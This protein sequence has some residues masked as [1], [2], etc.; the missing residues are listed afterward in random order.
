VVSLASEGRQVGRHGGEIVSL[1]SR[2]RDI[3]YMTVNAYT[4]LVGYDRALKIGPDLLERFENEGDRVFTFT[5]REGHRWSDGHPFT[6]E[7]FRFWWEDIARNKELSPA[8]L[9]DFMLVEGEGPRFELIDARTIRYTWTKPNPRFLPTLAQPRDPFIYRPAHYLKQFHAKYGDKAKLAE[10][11]KAQK[12]K[13]WAGLFNRLD[14]MFEASNP[15]LP[16]LHG[17][18]VTNSSPATR[19]VFERNPFYHRVDEA[20]QQLPYL[21]R[22]LMDVAAGGL[23]AAKANSGDAD[24]LARGLTMGDIP[25]LKEGETAKGYRTLMWPYARGSEIALYPKPHDARPGLAQ[26]EPGSPLPNGLV[27]RHRPEDAE[28][29]APVRARHGGQ[30]H[31]HRG[32]PP[33]SAGDEDDSRRLRSGQGLRPPR[34]SRSVRPERGRYPAPA[35]RARARNHRRD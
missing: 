25:I 14:D 27:P 8:G 35:G 5:L 31:D 18:R 2:A 1:V 29:R 3:R 23:M 10:T 34:R 20:G 9:P 19:F 21:D 24:L 26:A 17:W 6:A 22:V 11:A 7:D 30:Q 12:M 13:S 28:Q 15:A 33:L 4:R 16:T 32:K